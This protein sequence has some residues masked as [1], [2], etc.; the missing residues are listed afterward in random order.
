MFMPLYSR[1]QYSVIIK[2]K[3]SCVAKR[4]YINNNYRAR[5]LQKKRRITNR[6][7]LMAGPGYW[8]FV[9]FCIA[10]SAFKDG[11]YEVTT[12]NK[13]DTHI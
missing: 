3:G 10:E 6:S 4:A 11:I 12:A 1:V 8:Y 13:I 5:C 2:R 9:V 7:R